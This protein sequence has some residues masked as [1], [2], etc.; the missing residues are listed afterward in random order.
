MLR[1]I[2]REGVVFIVREC[3]IIYLS[4][5]KMEYKYLVAGACLDCIHQIEK[6]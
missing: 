3:N 4:S 2:E 1:I 5:S 6:G